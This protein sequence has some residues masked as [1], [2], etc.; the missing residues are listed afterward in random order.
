M[1]EPHV[2]WCERS[3]S[4][5]SMR[6]V[7]TLIILFCVGCDG[8]WNRGN[9]GYAT[10]SLQKA[11]SELGAAPD[12]LICNMIGAT[13]SFQCLATIRTESIDR[14]QATLR[15]TVSSLVHTEGACASFSMSHGAQLLMTERNRPPNPPGLE[16]LVTSFD[17]ATG[18]ACFESSHSYG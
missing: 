8:A 11:L 17:K 15:L 9:R 13:R 14:L 18:E 10:E 2:R 7:L 6:I 4:V 3:C 12:N 16:Y 1:R 5:T